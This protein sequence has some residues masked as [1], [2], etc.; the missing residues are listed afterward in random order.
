MA[1]KQQLMSGFT[2]NSTDNYVLGN[3]A[4][5]V[6]GSVAVQITVPSAWSG[7]IVV[8]G[9]VKG[10]GSWV[11]IP[12]RRRNLGG[13]VS[14]DTV[15]SAAITAAALI[16]VDAAGLDVSLDNTHTSGAA[17]VYFAPVQG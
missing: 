9:R 11:P 15:V 6:V 8:K 4:E 2:V 5:G 10:S 1:D 14:D 7:S 13:T 3:A 16:F 17:V 12:Y